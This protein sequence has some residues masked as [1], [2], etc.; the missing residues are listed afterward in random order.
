MG[1]FSSKGRKLLLC[2]NSGNRN[3]QY[4]LVF[5][6]VRQLYLAFG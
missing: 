2:D 1:N 3:D 4:V 5:I 6:N